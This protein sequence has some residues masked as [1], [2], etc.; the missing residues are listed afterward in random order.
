M[1]I[2]IISLKENPEYL[3]KV[4]DYCKASWS[5]V[6]DCFCEA[7]E[8]SVNADTLPQTWILMCN[9]GIAG[10]YQLCESD[11][12]LTQNTHLTPFLCT[13]FVDARCRGRFFGEMLITHAKYE[14]DKL[15]YDRLYVSTD[16]IGY[17]EKYG[18]REI[19]LDVCTYGRASKIYSADT[20]SEVRL[21]IYDKQNP[22]PD[23]LHIALYEIKH[24]K[25]DDPAVLLRF[26]KH[27]GIPEGIDT[28]WFT[29]VAFKD[30][31]PVGRVNFIRNNRDPLNWYLGDL[32]VVP[33]FR[34]QRIA[35]KMISKGLEFISLRSSGGEFVY[36]Y[37]EKDNLPSLKLH[38]SLGFMNSGEIKP[39]MDLIFGE[40]E[41]T[42]IK[43]I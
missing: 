3:S 43:I 36:S 7:A 27:L 19:G 9:D 21:E 30:Y 42:Y 12:T 6:Y 32:V 18:F 2:E 25:S 38:E 22:K 28:K 23:W 40:D 10:F 17:Y 26:L 24:G 5:K 31:R 37:I 29:I 13:L 33:E 4:K 14:A 8:K 39:F 41:T 1:G 15:G 34:R 16:H 35:S 20:L 11:C